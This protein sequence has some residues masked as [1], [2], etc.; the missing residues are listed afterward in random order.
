MNK[1]C[2]KIWIFGKLTFFLLAIYQF[3]EKINAQSHAGIFQIASE[4]SESV[5]LIVPTSKNNLLV[6]GIFN[7]SF[8][9]GEKEV[10]TQGENDCFLAKFNNETVDW[11]LSFGSTAQ[12][13]ILALAVDK[14][15]NAILCISYLNQI[16]IADSLLT[17]NSGSRGMLL[18]KISPNGSIIWTKDLSGTGE[19]FINQMVV[20]N[21]NQIY[22]CGYFGDTLNI[23]AQSMTAQAEQ[24]LLV[25]KL[26]PNGDLIWMQQAGLQGTIRG[27]SLSLSPLQDYINVSG[28][29]NGQVAFAE[30]TIQANTNDFD[31]FVAQFDSTGFR[32]GRK[33]GGVFEDHNRKILT[34]ENEDIFVIGDFQ[35][36]LK[37]SDDIQVNTN[38]IFDN[39]LYLLKYDN[40]GNPLWARS[41]GGV[42][43]DFVTDAIWINSN[44]IAVAGYFQNTFVIDDFSA[45]ATGNFNSY[46]TALSSE[47]GQA[48]WLKSIRGTDLTI[49]NSLAFVNNQLVLGGAFTNDLESENVDLESAGFFD[50]FLLYF[51]ALLTSTTETEHKE[52]AVR[53]F[54]NP[55]SEILYLECGIQNYTISIFSSTGQLVFQEKN[56]I[57]IPIQHWKNGI[58]FGKI[59][60]EKSEKAVFKFIKN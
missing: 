4:Q 10:H 57:S 49:G 40:L 22:A 5:E 36:T 39:N 9:W 17:P 60:N 7:D 1:F 37:L 54:P 30:D 18:L 59:W 8:V 16:Q 55:A 28:I 15:D 26:T 12:D 21:Q 47:D 45:E 13:E 48:Q 35:G 25:L 44:Q 50:A 2:T 29:Y 27:Q 20:N 43:F 14:N 6:A 56:T 33:A 11:L 42:D 19:Q 53:I 46:V 34:H 3:P 24:D 41:L 51:D 38:G 52:D 31:V 58:Y 23:D 32:W